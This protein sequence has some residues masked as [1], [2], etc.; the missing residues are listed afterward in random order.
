M[1]IPEEVLKNVVVSSCDNVDSGSCD[2]YLVGT[3]HVSQI[4]YICLSYCKS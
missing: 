4:T 1:P 2:V 3:G